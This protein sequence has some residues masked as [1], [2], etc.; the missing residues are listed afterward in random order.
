M[1]LSAWYRSLL[2]QIY[3]HA[4]YLMIKAIHQKSVKV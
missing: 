2:I 4:E 3:E 1:K